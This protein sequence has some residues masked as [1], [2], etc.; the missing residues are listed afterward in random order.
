MAQQKTKKPTQRTTAD[1]MAEL[2]IAQDAVVVKEVQLYKLW[3]HN[4]ARL[5]H[6]KYPH[7]HWIPMEDSPVFV[8]WSEADKVRKQLEC[9]NKQWLYEPRLTRVPETDVPKTLLK[10]LKARGW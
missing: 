4:R 10:K 2:G 7:E 5:D 8:T 6:T 3:Q 9:D 1:L